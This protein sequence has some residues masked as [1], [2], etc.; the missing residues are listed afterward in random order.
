MKTCKD[1]VGYQYD[2][3]PYDHQ[4]DDTE[5]KEYTDGDIRNLCRYFKDYKRFIELPCSIGDYCIWE[6][7]LWYVTGIHYFND[8]NGDF[9]L[10]MSM[11]DKSPCGTEAISSQV[12]F[13][14]EDEAKKMLE[15]LTNEKE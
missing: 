8:K 1:C 14:S 5:I 11:A 2:W 3:C 13:I 15:E 6:D 12:K 9:L 7:D 4:Y 10:W